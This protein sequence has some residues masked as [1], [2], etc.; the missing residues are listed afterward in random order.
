MNHHVAVD[1]KFVLVQMY[2]AYKLNSDA[3]M[4]QEAKRKSHLCDEVRCFH[5]SMYL[6]MYTHTI[7]L[8]QENVNICK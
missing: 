3:E 5:C 4:L 8:F 6:K 1:V 2:C 7:I